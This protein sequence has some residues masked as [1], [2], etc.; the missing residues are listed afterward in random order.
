MGNFYSYVVG[1]YRTTILFGEVEG[2]NESIWGFRILL[3]PHLV[4]LHGFRATM[5]SLTYSDVDGNF[6]VKNT[7]NARRA[8]QNEFC[9]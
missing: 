5:R 6:T 8:L 7:L 9:F 2:R 4:L 1:V 3:H